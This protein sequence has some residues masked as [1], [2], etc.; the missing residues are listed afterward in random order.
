MIKGRM[1]KPTLDAGS[2]GA[3][4]GALIEISGNNVAAY[5]NSNGEIIYLSP[6]CKHL[7]CI[8]GW[9]KIEKTWD[10]PCHGSRYE[11]DGILKQ[12]PARSG[13]DKIN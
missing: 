9:N 7:G 3:G 10:C 12:G 5:K 11:A 13:L 8:V 6:V 2:L 1:Q 4:E